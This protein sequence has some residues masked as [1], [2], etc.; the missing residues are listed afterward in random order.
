MPP[1]Q[2]YDNYLWREG[3][4]GC[5]AFHWVGSL[6]AKNVLAGQLSL[7]LSEYPPPAPQGWLAQNV[8]LRLDFLLL[9]RLLLRL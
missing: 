4:G 1:S 7:D 5:A 3:A 9:L 8:V 6:L 2:L